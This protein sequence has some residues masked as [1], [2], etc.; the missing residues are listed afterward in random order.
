MGPEER[1]RTASERLSLL[2]LGAI[3]RDLFGLSPLAIQERHDEAF[4]VEA[5]TKQ[6]FGE[7]RI[8]FDLL[9]KDLSTQTKD[10]SWAHD[11]KILKTEVSEW[12]GFPKRS[13]RR[14]FERK[15]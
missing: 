9:Q 2:D 4:D 13:T 14:S 11:G 3:G 7:Y 6:F 12:K 1:L 5:V 8:V 15:Q 10:K